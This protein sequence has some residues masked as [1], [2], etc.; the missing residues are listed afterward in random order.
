MP[1]NSTVT[2]NCSA[3]A[4][5][6]ANYIFYQNGNKM[7][8]SSSNVWKTPVLPC[9]SASGRENFSCT[10]YNMV[11]NTSKAVSIIVVSKYIQ[12]LLCIFKP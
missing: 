5:P 8:N 6:T 3:N 7:Q 1:I 2:F 4:R 11:G 9:R 12:K 10:A